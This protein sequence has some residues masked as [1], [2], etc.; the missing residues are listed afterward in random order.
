MDQVNTI[1]L[2]IGRTVRKWKMKPDV[3]LCNWCKTISCPIVPRKYI[4]TVQQRKQ[5]FVAKKA[6]A[7]YSNL[8]MLLT[9]IGE[10]KSPGPLEVKIQFNLNL[11]SSF[12]WLELTK[13]IMFVG[14]IWWG[15][16]VPWAVLSFQ[17]HC[18]RIFAETRCL[19]SLTE[20]NGHPLYQLNTNFQ[21][22]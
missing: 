18:F 8:I 2:T 6:M 11:F 16:K 1:Q 12:D 7:D 14:N 10:K 21:L 17:A 20:Y 13:F 22:N 3:H 9:S 4:K 15:F 5:N 19:T